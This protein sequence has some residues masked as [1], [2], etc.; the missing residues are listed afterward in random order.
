VVDEPAALVG[1]VVEAVFDDELPQAP[2]TS[3]ATTTNGNSIF[4]KASL[5]FQRDLRADAG[6]FG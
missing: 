4:L 1:A 2:K 5:R 3:A 6:A